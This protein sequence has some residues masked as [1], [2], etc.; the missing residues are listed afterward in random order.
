MLNHPVCSQSASSPPPPTP[1]PS[2]QLCSQPQPSPQC[3]C[4]GTLPRI[5]TTGSCHSLDQTGL[6]AGNP[7]SSGIKGP[8]PVVGQLVQWTALVIHTQWLG[9]T[10]TV[11]QY[12]CT[13]ETWGNHLRLSPSPCQDCY[14]QP[15]SG[16]IWILLWDM[17][18]LGHTQ[19]GDT[20]LD[21]NLKPGRFI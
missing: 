8:V 11:Q 12:S 13:V 3:R 9:L 1:S 16:C 19:P 18:M 7:G 14:L 2:L 21:L 10:Y 15:V 5:P 20:G 17:I 6:A 4:Q